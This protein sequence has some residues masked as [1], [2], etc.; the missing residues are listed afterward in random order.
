MKLRRY[1]GALIPVSLIV[2]WE[3]GAQTGVLPHDTMSRPSEIAV[4]G[5][6][7]LMDG[8]LL[9][10]TLQTFETALLGLAIGSSI[11]ILIGIFIGLSPILEGIIGPTLDTV[12]PIP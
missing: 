2:L 10:A 11:G 9:I 1:R 12:R 3:I 6:N 5:W 8:S 4:A 7:A